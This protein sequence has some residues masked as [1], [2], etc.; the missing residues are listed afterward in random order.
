MIDEIRAQ[1]ERAG[2]EVAEKHAVSKVLRAA[3]YRRK[4]KVSQGKTP[5]GRSVRMSLYRDSPAGNFVLVTGPDVAG[6]VVE[7]FPHFSGHTGTVYFP[8][9]D[10]HPALSDLRTNPAQQTK[11]FGGFPVLHFASG[12]NQ[13]GEIRGLADIGKAVGASF[14]RPSPSK[15]SPEKWK[16]DCSPACVVELK[17]AMLEGVPVFLDS[18]AYSEF[19]AGGKSPITA[20]MWKERLNVYADLA[21][22]GA[23][24]ANVV[25]PDK[26]GDQ[27]ESFKR[28]RKYAPQLRNLIKKGASVLVPLQSGALTLPQAHREATKVLKT[29]R[30]IPAL[31]FQAETITDEEFGAY[32]AAIRPKRVH[33]LGIGPESKRARNVVSQIKKNSPDT[34]VQMD[35]TV[36]RSRVGRARAI[37]P[38]T[39]AQDAARD[40]L[41][42]E[43]DYT[44]EDEPSQL[45]SKAALRRIAQYAG[46]SSAETKKLLAD[47]DTYFQSNGPD[48]FYLRAGPA[49]E[50]EMLRARERGETFERKRRAIRSDFREVAER[51]RFIENPASRF[52]Y[53]DLE[54]IRKA[55]PAMEAQGVS[56]VARS[57][58]GFLAAYENAGGDPLELASMTDRHSGENWA[59]RRDNFVARHR[60]QLQGTGWKGGN[61]TRRHLALV[62]WAYS[63]TPGKLKRWASRQ[64]NPAPGYESWSW[65]QEDWRS[66]KVSNQGE[67][68]YSEKCGADGT[69][70]AS[71]KPRLCLPVEAIRSLMKSEA[72]RSELR[73]QARK[74]A[75]AAKGERVPY[76][77]RV[78]KAVKK[79]TQDSP[80]D[81]PQR[82]RNPAVGA[83]GTAIVRGGPSAPVKFLEKQG[84]IKSPVLD[85][86]SGHGED[87]KWLRSK[88]YQVREYDPNF[89]GIADMPEGTYNTVLCIYVLN[90][91]PKSDEARIIK[92]VQSRLRPNGMAYFAVRGDVKKSG[93]TSRGYQRPVKLN[94]ETVGK[95]SG[96][97]IFA[98]TKSRHSRKS[99]PVIQFPLALDLTQHGLDKFVTRRDG[100]PEMFEGRR[101]FY[102]LSP[103]SPRVQ[104]LLLEYVAADQQM[105]AIKPKSR[106]AEELIR[107]KK[108]RAKFQDE[109]TRLEQEHRSLRPKRFIVRDA[110]IA[111]MRNLSEEQRASEIA[112][113]ERSIFRRQRQLDKSHSSDGPVSKNEQ[114]RRDYWLLEIDELLDFV[115]LLVLTDPSKQPSIDSPDPQIRLFNP[116]QLVQSSTESIEEIGSD[117]DDEFDDLAQNRTAYQELYFSF[118]DDT[119]DD[120]NVKSHLGMIGLLM[121]A[122]MSIDMEIEIGR[123]PEGRKIGDFG[124]KLLQ[125]DRDEYAE[126][127]EFHAAKL[128]GYLGSEQ[129][130]QELDKIQARLDQLKKSMS[131]GYYY[132]KGVQLPLLAN[133]RAVVGK[134]RKDSEGNKY[135]LWRPVLADGSRPRIHLSAD[136]PMDAELVD[137]IEAK[138]QLK[139]ARRI[140]E[141]REKEDRKKGILGFWKR[142]TGRKIA[143]SKGSPS[144][145]PL[146]RASTKVPL[147]DSEGEEYRATYEVFA[148][149]IDGLGPVLASNLPENFEPTP[150]YPTVFQARTLQREGEKQK[151]RKIARNLDPDRLLLHHSDPTFGTPVV[152]EGDGKT[153]KVGTQTLFTPTGKY[154]VLGGNGRLMAILMAPADRFQA[155]VQRGRSLWPDIWPPGSAPSGKRRVLVR[156][157]TKVNGDPLTFQEARKLAGRTQQSPA[158]EESPIGKSLSLIRSLGLE[159][160]SDL[161]QFVWDRLITQDNVEDFMAENRGYTEAVLNSMGKARAESYQQDPALMAQLFNNLMVGYLPKRF[162]LR[163]FVGEK[164]ERALLS[165]LPIVVAIH[166][167]VE[168]GDVL[169]KW[170]LFPLLDGAERFAAL[171]K[172]LTNNKA[173]ALVEQAAAQVQLG[174]G[175][176]LE[177]K[178]QSLFDDLPLL[179]VMFGLVLKKGER[180]RDPAITI[181]DLL[182]PYAA[183]ALGTGEDEDQLEQGARQTG[184][185]AAIAG[186]Y[187]DPDETTDPAEY[188]AKQLKVELPKRVRAQ[189]GP[190]L[191]ERVANPP[192]LSLGSGFQLRYEMSDQERQLLASLENYDARRWHD[193]LP[194]AMRKL[195]QLRYARV[196]RTF[197]GSK[198]L[199]GRRVYDIAITARGLRALNRARG[200][201]RARMEAAQ[202]RMFNPARAVIGFD[203]SNVIRGRWIPSTIV[204]AGL[205]FETEAFT[206]RGAKKAAVSLNMAVNDEI[207]S[208][209][210]ATQYGLR[211]V[212]GIGPLGER[213]GLVVVPYGDSSVPDSEGGTF[214]F[215]NKKGELVTIPVESLESG[216]EQQ[217]RL[218]N[219]DHDEF[220]FGDGADWE[221]DDPGD[222]L[223]ALPGPGEQMGLFGGVEY[224]AEN[225]SPRGRL[226]I[227]NM[228]L[229]RDSISMICLLAKNQLMVNGEFLGPKDVDAVVFSDTGA[230][231]RHTMDLIPRVQEFAEKNGIRFIWLQKPVPGTETGR[232]LQDWLRTM[233]QY[234]KDREQGWADVYKERVVP[235]YAQK[236][237]EAD[238][239]RKER[240]QEVREQTKRLTAQGLTGRALS[241]ALKPTRD[242]WAKT[243]KDHGEK[244]KAV[245]RKW[246]KE[247]GFQFK[248]ER[249]WWAPDAAGRRAKY[250]TVEKRAAAG[251]YHLRPEILT[252]FGWKGTIPLRT[253]KSCTGNHKV[254]PIRKVTEDLA[255]EKFGPWA[256]NSSWGNAVKKGKRE[257]HLNLI[258]LAADETDRL[259]KGGDVGCFTARYVTEAYPL[260]EMGIGKKDEQPIL[261]AC[262]FGDVR[263]SGCWMCP[264]QPIGWWWA[265]SE[266]EPD[267]FA[268]AVKAEAESTKR[269][270]KLFF[271]GSAK[272]KRSEQ[273]KQEIETA[274]A[275]RDQ[276]LRELRD[277]KK[278]AIAQERK[279]AKIA[280]IPAE[281]YKKSLE[282]IRMG[283]DRA[284][285]AVRTKSKTDQQNIRER[286]AAMGAPLLPEAVADWRAAHPDADPQDVLDKQYAK[287]AIKFPQKK[288]PALAEP[289]C[290]PAECGR[291]VELWN[292]FGIPG[293]LQ[294]FDGPPDKPRKNSVSRF[295]Q[296]LFG[297][298]ALPGSGP[299]SDSPVNDYARIW[300]EIWELEKKAGNPTAKLV[301]SKAGRRL[302]VPRKEMDVLTLSEGR[303]RRLFNFT[304]D[305][306]YYDLII[307]NSSGGK[308]SLAIIDVMRKLAI[309]QG[310][311][312][313]VRIVHA[314]LGE[315]EHEGVTDL[316]RRQAA[317]VNLPVDILEPSQGGVKKY[318]YERF[319]QRA[320]QMAAKG[321]T[322]KGFPGFG[323]R[324]CT[325][326]FKTSEVSK[327]FKAYLTENFGTGS[328]VKKYGRRARVL[329]VLGMRAQ[330]SADR[331]KVKGMATENQTE[332]RWVEDRWLPIQGWDE[333]RVWDTIRKS[334]LEYHPAYEAGFKR[335]SCRLCPLASKEDVALASLVYPEVTAQLIDIE[336][337]TGA[338]F[339]QE[340]TSLR[341]I[342]EWAES[343]PTVKE[344]ASK[345][346][347]VLG[348]ATA[349]TRRKANPKGD[350]CQMCEARKI[351]DAQAPQLRKNMA[352]IQMFPSLTKDEAKADLFPL[353]SKTPMSEVYA[354]GVEDTV[355][356]FFVPSS[357]GE[358]DASYGA[359]LDLFLA[360]AFRTNVSSVHGMERIDE[361]GF[362]RPTTTRVIEALPDSL[363]KLVAESRKNRRRAV[364]VS[365]VH[366][367]ADELFEL[368]GL[369]WAVTAAK[370]R[371]GRGWDAEAQVSTTQ[372]AGN[373]AD[374]QLLL[375]ATNGT[376]LRAYGIGPIKSLVAS[377][378][379]TRKAALSK[380]IT[381]AIQEN[382]DRLWDAIA[383]IRPVPYEAVEMT[384][385]G[386]QR[387][388]FQET[389]ARR[390]A[391]GAQQSKLSDER[392]NRR[393]AER[394][395]QLFKSAWKV[396]APHFTIERSDRE[397]IGLDR[398]WDRVTEGPE[399]L[400]ALKKIGV[401]DGW[402]LSSSPDSLYLTT[403]P[404]DDP[405]NETANQLVLFSSYGKRPSQILQLAQQ[406]YNASLQSPD[407]I[408]EA[409]KEGRKY[410]NFRL[411]ST[412]FRDSDSYRTPFRN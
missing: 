21:D 298:A 94:A 58:R 279:Q 117:E 156:I 218:L 217:V 167:A 9:S 129:A 368:T 381:L 102:D 360:A 316:V 195:F 242:K 292:Q 177:T 173:I 86:G 66:I 263:K 393:R 294:R 271:V 88:G 148:T 401:A 261:D 232:Q 179:A 238:E 387:A 323:T 207:Q 57:S 209:W 336:D 151:I 113:A 10:G 92:Q 367:A 246:K 38:L 126:L 397:S 214:R 29:D 50:Q 333:K 223:D 262:G 69:K 159:Q 59:S 356:T 266:L 312:D 34:A 358:L 31:P 12:S 134:I 106:K 300:D 142:G 215:F 61:P 33:L 390:Q 137:A 282:S 348:R 169:P 264:F 309:K 53:L 138:E 370:S 400:R 181:A 91:L 325:S 19:T 67:I 296:G 205:D 280:G 63:P 119:A 188:L 124:K 327:W 97:P 187:G 153:H 210:Q 16:R 378:E 222:S 388:Y 171:T 104:E 245:V 158:G 374:A 318:L 162:H 89:E 81:K 32:L 121:N 131:G 361:F 359:A 178:F 111:M 357:P 226:V 4:P 45:F 17:N 363:E 160:V 328:L 339:H 227:L 329:N 366:E 1:V 253:D 375:D 108:A 302:R 233:T 389:E 191:F 174:E 68:D 114:E 75:R 303:Q 299:D 373:S 60:A 322:G 255:I 281:Q 364:E 183:Q 354:K 79:A 157:A 125:R 43:R 307:V 184:M 258:G 396:W 410:G 408:L 165:A 288:N 321:Q 51:Q 82:N 36:I 289:G 352:Q 185:L 272:G 338:L 30:W 355:K 234:R 95:P 256:N 293:T 260:A 275:K 55:V 305:L 72:G 236:N 143:V 198:T 340:K 42:M 164:Q 346:R 154:Y 349:A 152:W 252:D 52:N 284:M 192:Q 267:L 270:P 80:R 37:G 241:S 320:E 334:G 384:A 344:L 48:P 155:Y 112:K 41:K 240:D 385:A 239:L 308:D 135:V 229:G 73:S 247:G 317:A 99:N 269:D 186:K 332:T 206:G 65:T 382:L 204:I 219:P 406:L 235:L 347:K 273:K 306:R 404:S 411:R 394:A 213:T 93:K 189:G 71:G 330:E 5:D 127:L 405:E 44:V 287:C 62:A 103:V 254:A 371:Y 83:G 144:A 190:S 147:F 150:G 249:A 407:Q 335:L 353:G 391:V 212:R 211:R 84:L 259:E 326:E 49:I 200:A 132:S 257:P 76:L 3:G 398:Y 105:E 201:D 250:D 46:L 304:P 224:T 22:S 237:E 133:P 87:A 311:S 14:G 168:T 197:A 351:L 295:Q 403:L 123:D 74:K 120:V 225:L 39:A 122:L 56:E 265:L 402:Q 377:S 342:R 116:A 115:D 85:F 345:A 28:L 372:T 64:Q 26:V 163:G 107:V 146:E 278:I 365:N 341:D 47:P 392:V 180:A 166:Q 2:T 412:R 170:D 343:Q 130:Q 277:D 25:A 231:W 35:S 7:L 161:P 310:V 315:A 286:Y 399:N 182:V 141:K 291:F 379:P 100:V 196:V 140:V 276:R 248:A 243:I 6:V 290:C 380:L 362:R 90:V 297:T 23:S 139:V 203:K 11:L 54:T 376:T 101:R 193:P 175:T 20:K 118:D 109:K 244:Y 395:S 149:D 220:D 230:E 285:T 274:R 145:R 199:A 337:Q 78:A 409:A 324:Y 24:L 13:P 314:D 319:Q 228:G 128:S 221:D 40:E 27:T 301:T 208:E 18:G 110:Q 8:A 251:V 216:I 268:R 202:Q 77:P 283:Y 15:R 383:A 369:E 98:M 194:E 70:T 350:V 331:A 176:E 386:K 313:R 136:E 96:S 172:T